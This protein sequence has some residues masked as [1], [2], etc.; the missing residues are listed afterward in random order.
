MNEPAAEP[1][2]STVV[3]LKDKELVDQICARARNAILTNLRERADLIFWHSSLRESFSPYHLGRFMGFGKNDKLDF[4][5]VAKVLAHFS[6]MK[7]QTF[8]VTWTADDESYPAVAISL[9]SASEWTDVVTEA[10]EGSERPPNGLSEPAARL[11]EWAR[12]EK[13]Q[14]QWTDR[15]MI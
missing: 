2:K 14:K 9:N 7:F 13:N 1:A 11:L 12:L 4:N 6:P 5:S 8:D 15:S 3:R 10:W